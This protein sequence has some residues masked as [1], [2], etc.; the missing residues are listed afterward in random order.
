MSKRGRKSSRA[1]WQRAGYALFRYIF[2][3]ISLTYFRYKV[4]NR[5]LVPKTGGAIIC[6]NHQSH[7]DPPV[8]GQSIPRHVCY[9]ARQSLFS[10]P[11]MGFIFH[12]LDAIPVQRGGGFSGVKNT[13]MRIKRGDVVVLFPEG[14]RSKD[15]KLGRMKSGFITL[16]RRGKVP[17]IPA[18][19]AG[20]YEAL[21]RG[22]IIPR[23]SNVRVTFGEAISVEQIQDMSDEE[24]IEELR[25]RIQVCM[26]TSRQSS[27][28]K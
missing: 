3:L 17:I 6:A 25:V 4:E 15:G 14:T 2:R 16:A 5:H 9:M 20:A 12:M 7:F 28:M 13:L 19:V 23:Q 10:N 8:V 11:F 24:V 26:E 22:T 21:P 27:R 1:L 18:G